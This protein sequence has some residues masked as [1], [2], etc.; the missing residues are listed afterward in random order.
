[1][2]G[3]NKILSW[4]GRLI[5]ALIALMMTFS[6]IMKF[7]NPPELAEQFVGKLGYP[8]DLTGSSRFGNWRTEF[9]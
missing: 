3:N 8:E 7:R 9:H 2:P 1:M 4:T 5:T 6:A